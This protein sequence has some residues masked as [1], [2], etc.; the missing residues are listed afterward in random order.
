M[1]AHHWGRLAAG[2]YPADYRQGDV[3]H[4]LPQQEVK[5]GKVF[6]AGTKLNGNHE[7]VTNGGRVLCVTALGETVAQAQQYAYQLA[8]GSSGKGFSAVK[9]LVIERLLAV[10]KGS[11]SLKGTV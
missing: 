7:V 1:S 2:G 6:H 3:I 10:S 11:L 4:G 8:E 9:I 5:D